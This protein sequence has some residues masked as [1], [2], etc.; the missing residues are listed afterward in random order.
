MIYEGVCNWCGV[1][2]SY[3]MT[4]GGK[5]R[6]C[7]D[8]CRE[9][10]KREAQKAR[11]KERLAKQRLLDKSTDGRILENLAKEALKHG[12]TYGKYVAMLEA[13]K[14]DVK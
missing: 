1:K 13:R 14:V 9:T 7:S 3:S 8:F 12:T 2:F 6:Y 10:A 4:R 5:L 11:E